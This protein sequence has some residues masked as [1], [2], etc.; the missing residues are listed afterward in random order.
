M[1]L[2]SAII[3]THNR[4][5]LLK[6]AIDS[7]FAQTYPNIELIVVDDHSED[8]TYEVCNDS[9]I[10]YIFIP[11]EESKGGNYARNLGIKSSKGKYCAFLDDDDY[12]LPEKIEKQY[13]LAEKNKAGCIYCLREFEI[14]DGKKFSRW[15]EPSNKPQGDLQNSIFR[16]YI[17]STSC[18]LIS[19][20]ILIEIEGFDEN[21]LK[22]QEYE[23]MIRLSEISEIYFVPEYLCIYL[24]DRNDKQRISN[25]TDRLR[26]TIKYIKGKYNNRINALPFKDRIQFDYMC[27]VDIYKL[28]KKKKKYCSQSLFIIKILFLKVLIMLSN[29]FSS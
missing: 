15:M 13:K 19:K 24:S 21:I 4:K 16:H 26:G 3:T 10:K 5:E 12:W 2:V 7:V 14:R 23:L 17:T 27:K 20:S 22:W 25:Q 9:R 11:K 1:D 8:G 6:R 29:I 18:L 28:E